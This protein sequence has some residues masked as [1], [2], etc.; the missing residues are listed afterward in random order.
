[1]KIFSKTFI[2]IL[3]IT[4]LVPLTAQ[5]IEKSRREKWPVLQGAVA[6]LGGKEYKVYF[7]PHNP[8]HI[9]IYQACWIIRRDT[10]V[11]VSPNCTFEL[12]GDNLYFDKTWRDPRG[13][14]TGV[15]W[16]DPKMGDVSLFSLIFRKPKFKEDSVSI[17]DGSQWI[18]VEGL[19][20][21]Q[22]KNQSE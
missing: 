18:H 22:R 20:P 21:L 19:P 12:D 7:D 13:Y 2:F 17:W 8:T 6:K 16:G 5:S 10:K 11:V 4:F 3:A 14:V 15:E 9:L 1:M